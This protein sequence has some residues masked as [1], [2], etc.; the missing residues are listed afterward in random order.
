MNAADK[1]LAD[2]IFGTVEDT[3]C[4]W[5]EMAKQYAGTRKFRDMMDEIYNIMDEMKKAY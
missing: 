3:L 1:V 2:I 5:I 4:N